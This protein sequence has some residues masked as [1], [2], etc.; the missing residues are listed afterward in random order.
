MTRTCAWCWAHYRDVAVRP[1]GILWWKRLLVPDLVNQ[2]WPLKCIKRQRQRQRDRER[3]GEAFVTA[4]FLAQTGQIL[5]T[6]FP[7]MHVFLSQKHMIPM[8]SL[9][10]QLSERQFLWM[11]IGAYAKRRDYNAIESL[12]TVKVVFLYFL[13]FLIAS[14]C[15]PCLEACHVHSHTAECSFVC[16]ICPKV[17]EL[18]WNF[19]FDR[20][21]YYIP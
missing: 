1:G 2:E 3:W 20:G 17:H 11:A 12:L 8:L 4:S 18:S 10:T 19:L 21:A 9:P 15:L 13:L 6:L 16:R 14:P 7:K 5:T